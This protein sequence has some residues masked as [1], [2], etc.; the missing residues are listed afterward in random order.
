MTS[1]D[2]NANIPAG[3]TY[4]APPP[5]VPTISTIV[6]TTGTG[7]GGD[8]L[9]IT[10]TNFVPGM[11]A[12]LDGVPVV[13]GQYINPMR[14]EC[15]SP[16]GV[17][18]PV[19]VMV[20]TTGGT[21]TLP[22][23]FTYSTPQPA[24]TIDAVTPASG[25]AAGGDSLVISGSHFEVGMTATIGGAP[26]ANGQYSSLVQFDCQSPSGTP[27]TA[28]V[29]VTTPG[30]TATLPGGFTYLDTPIVT[31]INPT[32]GVAADPVSIAGQGF[33][34]VDLTTG[35]TF[36]GVNADMITVVDDNNITC[37]A[38]A[39]LTGVVDVVVTNPQGPYTSVS[40]FSYG[41]SAE[42]SGSVT[43][44]SVTPNQ[45]DE[46]GGDTVTIAGAGFAGVDASTGVTFGGAPAT[47]IVTVDGGTITC[48][49]PPASTTV[50]SAKPQP[51]DM[52][53]VDV[54]V[55]ATDGTAMLEGGYNYLI[56]GSGVS[57]AST[58]PDVGA[59]AQTI[60]EN[61]ETIGEAA[62]N[63][64]EAAQSL[65][66]PS[67]TDPAFSPTSEAPSASTGTT[68]APVTGQEPDMT[69]YEMDQ[70]WGIEPAQ[71]STPE[72]ASSS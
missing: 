64:G 38:P 20:T 45:G 62:Q 22:G 33:T 42:P 39:G 68:E 53:A 6:P 9:V 35:V 23:G 2:C 56:Y 3:F 47:N 40:G 49:T 52:K 57:T 65:T 31:S 66:E 32:N 41:E 37:Q 14:F 13:A 27:G 19:D 61:A 60:Q 54:A 12:A 1:P 18:G 48:Q 25:G 46:G 7:A 30:G 5:P 8:A 34:G 28:D 4:V 10:G 17:D 26:V 43:V 59:V 21:A 15:T 58:D 63:I 72:P 67:G 51:P 36:G 24:P 29:S 70:L 71:G 50:A 55:A 69:E 11:T 44:S 16:P